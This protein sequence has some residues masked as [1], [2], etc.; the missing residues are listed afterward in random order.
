[1]QLRGCQTLSLQDA[2]KDYAKMVTQCAEWRKKLH[3]DMAG[4]MWWCGLF[5]HG[6]LRF[7][8]GFRHILRHLTCRQGQSLMVRLFEVGNVS[9]PVLR[10]LNY[11][12]G[13][14]K[15]TWY[16]VITMFTEGELTNCFES[17]V[18]RGPACSVFCLSLVSGWRLGKLCNDRQTLYTIKNG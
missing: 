5:S 10:L 17:S 3:R 2:H 9:P 18:F 11:T 7:F 16:S 14:H 15:K 12:V 1:M 13:K 8:T 6:P 4:K